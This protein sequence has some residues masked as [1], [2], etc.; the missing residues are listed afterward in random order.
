MV[1]HPI[2]FWLLFGC[3]LTIVIYPLSLLYAYIMVSSNFK[4]LRA[5]IPYSKKIF[6]YTIPFGVLFTLF[7]LVFD[8]GT[9]FPHL[10]IIENDNKVKEQ[11]LVFGNEEIGEFP[12]FKDNYVL[13]NTEDTIYEYQQYYS[14][15]FSF[16]SD[17][18]VLQS[19]EPGHVAK[20]NSIPQGV[21]KGIPERIVIRYRN[22]APNSTKRTFIISQ[23]DYDNLLN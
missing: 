17:N 5:F 20:L 21:M 19:I 9:L 18:G 11:Y 13:N 12:G 16:T 10:Y 1:L 15:T 6:F 3:I 23:K 14:N 2:I 4:N 8:L 7:N 22:F